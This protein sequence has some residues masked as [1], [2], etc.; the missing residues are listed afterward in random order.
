ML[1]K[2]GNVAIV[3]INKLTDCGN[4]A[5]AVRAMDKENCGGWARAGIYG[6]HTVLEIQNTCDQGTRSSSPQYTDLQK[7]I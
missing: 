3:F 7:K 2:K 1:V 6:V 4:N 5:F